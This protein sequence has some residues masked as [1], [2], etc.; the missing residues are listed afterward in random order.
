MT[1]ILISDLYLVISLIGPGLAVTHWMRLNAP[2]RLVTTIGISLLLNY[3]AVFAVYVA[4]YQHVGNHLLLA[5][6]IVLLAVYR[7]DVI[8]MLK[9]VIVRQMLVGFLIVVLWITLINSLILS[10]SGGMWTGDWIEHYHRAIFFLHGLSL[11]T[12]FLGIYPLTARPPLMNL[13]L[14]HYMAIFGSEYYIFQNLSSLLNALS[15][16]PVFL[17]LHRYSR[18]PLVAMTI[19]VILVILNPLF[20]QNTTYTW[21]KLLTAYFVVFAILE[22]HRYLIGNCKSCLFITWVMLAG[23]VLT[24]YSAIPYALFIFLHFMYY[25]IR[26][27]S[28]GISYLV[29]SMVPGGMLLLSWF[30]WSFVYFGIDS[31]LLSNTTVIDSSRLD[32][33]DNAVKI[34]YNIYFSLLPHFISGAGN[35]GFSMLDFPAYPRDFAFLLYQTNMVFALGSMGLAI[36]AYILINRKLTMKQSPVDYFWVSLIILS[37]IV[38]IAVHGTLDIYGV[39]HICLQPVVLLGLAYIATNYY[40]IGKFARIMLGMGLMIDYLFGIL[41]HLYIQGIDPR[42]ETW[43]GLG[44]IFHHNWNLKITTELNFMADALQEY[45]PYLWLAIITGTAVAFYFMARRFHKEQH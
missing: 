33:A 19:A 35:T 16:F 10:F 39:I 43:S 31:T 14:S 5:I 40:S 37:V 20:I 6:N 23:G 4:D 3:L 44:N 34:L 11:D 9:H 13:L 26:T 21:T 17:L 38:G 27:R 22:Y 18:N 2:T 24:H 29:G 8:T 28:V 30:A 45:N 32:I 12:Q 41:L 15:V 7:R 1:N 42:Q 25:A 36:I